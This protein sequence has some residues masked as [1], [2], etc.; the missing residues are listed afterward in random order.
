[1]DAIEQENLKF[2]GSDT[3]LVVSRL[4]GEEFGL[5]IMSVKEIIRV[6][7][8]TKLPHAPAFVEGVMN[9]RGE[10]IPVINL[11][12]RFR[13][14]NTRVSEDSRII[15]G[16][17]GRMQVGL[18]VDN[19]TEVLRLDASSIMPLPENAPGFWARFIAG[20]ARVNS[21]PLLVLDLEE[22]VAF[23]SDAEE[24][25]ERAPEQLRQLLETVPVAGG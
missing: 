9:L 21:R 11:R 17:V 13:M 16:E 20:V 7:P 1:V 14:R 3:Q 12:K 8:I 22:L 5:E 24:D 23:G 10:V 19:V 6:S 2:R 15:I 18:T 4:G 25:A